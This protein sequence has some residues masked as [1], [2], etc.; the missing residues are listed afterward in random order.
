VSEPEQSGPEPA[1]TSPIDVSEVEE[2]ET[3]A[4]QEPESA[5]EDPEDAEPAFAVPLWMVGA[6]G[7]GL[8]VIGGL[9]WF[10]IRKRKQDQQ[11]QEK[12]ASERETLEDLQ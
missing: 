6:A 5:P 11:A 3:P 4:V 10:A 8:L 9:V 1:I 7:G 2:P 12:A